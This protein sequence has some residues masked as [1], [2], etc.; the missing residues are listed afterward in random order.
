MPKAREA[1]AGYFVAQDYWY[2]LSDEQIRHG[3]SMSP[4]ERLSWLDETRRFMLLLRNAPR[5]YYRQG[6]PVTAIV[7]EVNLR[8]RSG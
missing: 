3:L 1:D 6:E 4:I 5:T 7:R 8:R 2:E